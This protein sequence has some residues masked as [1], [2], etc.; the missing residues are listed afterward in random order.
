E[1]LDRDPPQLALEYLCAALG[2]GSDRQYPALD[3]DSPAAA[4]AHRSDH[5]R[6]AAVHV[7][8]K[9]RV[10][11]DDRIVVLGRR[12]H[13]VDDDA[14]LLARVPARHAADA[15]LID[16]LGG[17]RGQVH[18]DRGP[19]AVPALGE[20]LGVDQDVDLARLVVGQAPGQLAL[21]GVARHSLCLH[22]HVLEGLGHVVGVAHAG[23]VHDAGHV[24]EAGLV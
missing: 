2:I 13:K 7:A 20:Q 24:V 9:Q 1:V 22:A 21:W 19:G 17:G 16:A 3:P 14:G 11:G 10:Q 6:A 5:D 23:G 4:A 12:V 18:A 8:V 15:L